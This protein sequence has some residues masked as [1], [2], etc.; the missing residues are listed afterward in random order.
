MKKDI[1]T[2]ILAITGIVLVFLPFILPLGFA[3][4][5]LFAMHRFQ[6][7]FLI[8]ME[9]FPAVLVG[10]GLLLWA[11]VRGRKYIKCIAWSL[12]ITIF[13]LFGSQ[14]L[15]VLAGLASGETEPADWRWAIVIAAIVIYWLTVIAIGVGGVLLVRSLYNKGDSLK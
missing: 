7:D 15:A 3:I 5:K 12:G 9:L 11:A 13:V 2:R 14:G 6:F 1:F 10:G 4:P 8:P